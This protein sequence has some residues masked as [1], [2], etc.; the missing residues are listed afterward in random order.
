MKISTNKQRKIDSVDFLKQ[1]LEKAKVFF[2]TDYRGLTH[3]QLEQLRRALKKVEAEYLVAKNTL[4]KLALE[5]SKIQISPA[6]S[7]TGRANIKDITQELKNPTATLLGYGDEIAPIKELANFIKTVQLPKIKLGFFG[8]KIVT[9]SDFKTI[10]TLPTKD[11]LLATL[12][13]YLQSPISG[14]HYALRWNLQR[15]VTV[16]DNVKGKKTN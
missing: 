16:L 11:V 8:G 9:S 2:L 10:S 5:K 4:F 6:S 3:Q 7:G 12:A 15:F 14:F 1:K 13:S